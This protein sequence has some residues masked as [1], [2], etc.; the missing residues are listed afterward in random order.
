M[1]RADHEQIQAVLDGTAT[2]IE[3]HRFQESL[4]K[5]PGLRKLYQSYALLHHS[6]AEEFQGQ[7]MVGPSRGPRRVRAAQ[8]G[9]KTG[10]FSAAAAVAILAVAIWLASSRGK[11]PAEPAIADSPAPPVPIAIDFSPD[12]G[13]R[14]EG[15]LTTREGGATALPG[16]RLVLD[17]G[18][19]RFQFPNEVI[20]YLEAPAELLYQ[21]AARVVLEEGKARFRVGP[22]GKGF[23][24]VT[25]SLEAIDLGTEFAV[26]SH[27]GAPD[28]LHVFEGQV[29]M[30]TPEG[31][32]RPLLY[33]GE[34]ASV[35]SEGRVTRITA[36]PEEFTDKLPEFHL[37]L[38]DHF[39]GSG[40]SLHG[41]LPQ[42]GKGAWEVRL[43][44]AVLGTQGVVGGGFQAFC[45]LDGPPLGKKHP[46]LVATLELGPTAA[47]PM[48]GPGWAGLSFYAGEEEMVFFGDSFGDAETWSLDVKQ[49]LD[50][51][52][53]EPKVVGPRVVTM[54]Y[55]WRNGLTTLHSGDK[56]GGPE[57]VEGRIAPHL[58][59]DAIRIGASDDATINIRQVVV[60][61]LDAAGG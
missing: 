55:D 60:R 39:H 58:P 47:G 53:P 16:T 32:E 33:A 59:I 54:V 12:A 45:K 2:E 25:S 40:G 49:G 8:S 14:F 44:T 10:L 48:H 38:E 23:A 5:D 18:V 36:R 4:R 29:E 1:K 57:L 35:S 9:W 20:G 31:R 52:L 7:A 26:V 46:L 22:A 6:L 19:A 17:K 43:G 15:E 24:V 21:E 28:E 51:I 41:R 34:A 61:L 50:P 27:R 37:A 3:F 13:W 42:T 11:S 30:R 56:P